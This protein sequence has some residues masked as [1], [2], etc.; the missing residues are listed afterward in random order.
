MP[1]EVLDAK[2]ELD[3]STNEETQPDV[4]PET[5]QEST[6][7]STVDKEP[8]TIEELLQQ[9]TKKYSKQEKVEEA[10]T[11]ESEKKEEPKSLEEETTTPTKSEEEEQVPFHTHPR[12]IERQEQLEALR[13]EKE[14]L[15]PL[16]EHSRSVTEYC[17]QNGISNEAF[18]QSLQL[19]AMAAK[20]P[21][22]FRAAIQQMADQLD[23]Q[24]GA[25][26]PD[27]IQRKVNEGIIDEESAKELALARAGRQTTEATLAEQRQQ[28]EM[29]RHAS[30]VQAVDNWSLQK[31][32]KDPD[33]GQKYDLVRDRLT[34]LA[35]TKPPQSTADA[36]ALA[37]QAY[38]DVDTMLGR[39][40]KP[41]SAPRKVIPSSVSSSQ[42]TK[43]KEQLD[44][45][46]DLQNVVNGIV[47]ASH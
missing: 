31:Q 15:S 24:T 18:N 12:W 6:E 1:E 2:P 42:A 30:L 45:W 36:V 34:V 14:A 21:K 47:A 38:R 23:T 41:T 43:P 20:D 25:R 28:V 10:S 40:R 35:Q 19:A 22:Q 29:Q 16:A 3:S 27:D 7:S 33:Y 9:T 39:F 37:E 17:K 32:Q 8:E 4:T 11:S 26:L 13:Q 46:D 44:S 5:T